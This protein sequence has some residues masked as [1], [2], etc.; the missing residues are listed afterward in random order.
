M[1]ALLWLV[2]V[3]ALAGIA[4]FATGVLDSDDAP[5]P[6]PEDAWRANGVEGPTE[7]PRRHVPAIEEFGMTEEAILALPRIAVLA[8]GK[9]FPP[10]LPDGRRR[11]GET[12]HVLNFEG[13]GEV[14]G[15]DVLDA[16]TEKMFIRVRSARDLERLQ[17]VERDDAWRHVPPEIDEVIACFADVGFDIEDHG[18]VLVLSHPESRAED[19]TGDR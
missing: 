14:R 8:E 2:P 7:G 18:H 10:P 19:R 4:V 15:Q 5:D 9:P 6:E 3:L 16:L 11:P 12:H 17:N 1:K 13:S